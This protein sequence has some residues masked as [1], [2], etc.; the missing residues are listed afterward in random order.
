MAANETPEAT[1]DDWYRL[2]QDGLSEK[3]KA[4]A[5]TLINAARELQDE[6]L[7]EA[8]KGLLEFTPE[9]TPPQFCDLDQNPYHWHYKDMSP[10]ER[11]ERLIEVQ[12]DGRCPF[13]SEAYLYNLLG[14]EDARTLLALMRPIWQAAGIGRVQQP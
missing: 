7:Q 11:A 14:K 10:E 3:V 12:A 8:V 2:A 1:A 9:Y 13:F 4:A 6:E 5:A